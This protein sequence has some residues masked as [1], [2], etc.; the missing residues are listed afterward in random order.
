MKPWLIIATRP[1]ASSPSIHAFPQKRCLQVPWHDPQRIMRM[2]GA[3][4][5]KRDARA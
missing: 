3:G 2:L 4:F 1:A 5:E